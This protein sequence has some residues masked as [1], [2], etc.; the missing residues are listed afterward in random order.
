MAPRRNLDK[1]IEEQQDVITELR[2]EVDYLKELG[3]SQKEAKEAS[4]REAGTYRAENERLRKEL[5]IA[6]QH[7]LEAA[8]LEGV[9]QGLERAGKID[10]A[11]I[12]A[13]SVH[14]NFR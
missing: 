3:I 4:Q 11:P 14:N 12:T 9:I 1:E 7:R 10:P 2:R 13:T 5:N 8:R 6:E